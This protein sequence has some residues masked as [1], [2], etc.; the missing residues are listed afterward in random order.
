MKKVFIVLLSLVS[1]SA[2]AEKGEICGRY[3]I[4]EDRYEGKPAN[5]FLGVISTSSSWDK[6]YLK[7]KTKKQK[8]NMATLIDGEDYCI[9]GDIYWCGSNKKSKCMNL[10]S[11]QKL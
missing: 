1:V 6:Y 5:E 10:D 2:F 3:V 8:T 9:S 11:F 4:S 7:P